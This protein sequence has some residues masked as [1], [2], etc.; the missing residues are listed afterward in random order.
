MIYFFSSSRKL[1]NSDIYIS[2]RNNSEFFLVNLEIQEQM[3]EVEVCSDNH[4]GKKI[5]SS[6]NVQANMKQ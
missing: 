1:K 5:R 3:I 2:F 4:T 6:I